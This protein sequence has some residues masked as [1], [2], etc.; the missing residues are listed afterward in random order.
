MSRPVASPA[1]PGPCASPCA[2]EGANKRIGRRKRAGA[3]V[4]PFPVT[5]A[6]TLMRRTFSPSG[7]FAR[8]SEE[9][10]TSMNPGARTRPPASLRVVADPA[11]VPNVAIR[12]S[13]TATAPLKGGAPVPSIRRAFSMIKS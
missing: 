10:C 11:T 13:Y 1:P 7:I 5:I 6:V 2:G 8:F 4:P 9:V 3:G 12:P